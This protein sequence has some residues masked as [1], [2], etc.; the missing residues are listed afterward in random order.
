LPSPGATRLPPKCFRLI[1]V[2]VNDQLIP[3]QII[4]N[5]E[6]P[7]YIEYLAKPNLP[8]LDGAKVYFSFEVLQST[9]YGFVSSAIKRLTRNVATTLNYAA[10]AEIQNVWATNSFL[11]EGAVRELR[12]V[13]RSLTVKADGWVMPKGSCVFSWNSEGG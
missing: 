5:E 8:T 11:S 4:T 12:D 1:E 2:R 10:S 13:P 9:H 3:V 7:D 6:D